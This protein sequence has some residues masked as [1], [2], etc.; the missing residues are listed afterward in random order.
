MGWREWGA[1]EG[2]GGGWAGGWA[3]KDDEDSVDKIFKIMDM[4]PISTKKHEWFFIDMV[5][6]SIAKHKMTCPNLDFFCNLGVLKF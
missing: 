1:D 2:V 3:P 5:S 4:K 6:I